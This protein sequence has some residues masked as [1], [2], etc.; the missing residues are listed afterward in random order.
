MFRHNAC[1]RKPRPFSPPVFGKGEEA[2]P[3]PS[4]FREGR[5]TFCAFFSGEVTCPIFLLTSLFGGAER[6]A[7][8][9]CRA[10]GARAQCGVHGRAC[11]QAPGMGIAVV[12]SGRRRRA[13][14]HARGHSC[15]RWPVRLRPGRGSRLYELASGAHPLGGIMRWAAGPRRAW[16]LLAAAA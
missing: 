9:C 15:M 2:P 10:S 8:V 11:W 5:S 1:L 12:R 14:T 6:G 3:P 4:C 13:C 7:R 16:G